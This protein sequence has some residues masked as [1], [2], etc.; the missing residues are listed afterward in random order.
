MKSNKVVLGTVQFGLEYGINNDSGKPNEE[1][2]NNILDTAYENGIRILDTAEAYGNSQKRIG[3]Y[4]KISKNKFKIITKFSSKIDNNIKGVTKRIVNN[5]E[6]L[7]ISSLYAYMFHSFSDFRLYY[8]SF[9]EEFLDMKKSGVI[10]KIGVSIYTNKEF[11]YLIDSKTQVDLI[12]IPYNLLDNLNQRGELISRAKAKNI[13][14][15]VRSVFLQG[16]FFKEYDKLVGS[17]EIF[18]PQIKEI[19]DLCNVNAI[20]VSDLAL[21]YVSSNDEIDNILIGVDTEEQLQ[22]NLLAINR[23]INKEILDKINYLKVTDKNMLNPS[24]WF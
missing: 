7:N 18:R 4:H 10:K 14:I 13:E 20:K 15:H 19:Q 1:V 3:G 5:L 16:L 12:Q 17:L 2:L 11:E 9:E 23:S 22:E 21:G 8:Q 6:D 24:N